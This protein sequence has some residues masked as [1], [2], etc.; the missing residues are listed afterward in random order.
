MGSGGGGPVEAV[1][2]VNV[3]PK[4]DEKDKKKI[5]SQWRIRGEAF[6]VGP[7]IE[8]HKDEK[9]QSSGVRT[10]KSQLGSRMRIVDEGKEGDWSWQR[11]VRALFGNQSP[12]IRGK[13]TL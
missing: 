7:D 3:Q 13:S 12:G 8:A 4:E 6:V 5:M 1:W 2:W 11:E 9:E 10:V